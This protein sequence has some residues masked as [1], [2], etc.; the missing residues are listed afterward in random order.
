METVREAAMR[1]DTVGLATVAGY[2]SV[3]LVLATS[4]AIGNVLEGDRFGMAAFLALIAVAVFAGA[5][6]VIWLARRDLHLLVAG[7]TAR[8]SGADSRVSD[9]RDDSRSA[10]C[11]VLVTKPVAG[12]PWSPGSLG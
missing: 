3:V 12:V 1:V 7:D 4:D 2:L 9:S 8:V 6:A 5:G 11:A 10:R